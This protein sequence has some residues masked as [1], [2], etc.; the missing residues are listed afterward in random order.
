MKKDPTDSIV[1]INEIENGISS[2]TTAFNNLRSVVCYQADKIEAQA[3]EIEDANLLLNSLGIPF[4]PPK[5]I[6]ERIRILTTIRGKKTK[7]KIS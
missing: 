5:P 4:W 2:I 6:A 3:K 1:H 7:R